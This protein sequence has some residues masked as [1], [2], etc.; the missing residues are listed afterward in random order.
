[1]KTN[2]IIQIPDAIKQQDRE[3][4]Q[5]RLDRLAGEAM[6]AMVGKSGAYSVSPVEIAEKSYDIAVKMESIREQMLVADEE[7]N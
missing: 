7:G 1:M 6:I 2:S 3:A 4:I 5:N